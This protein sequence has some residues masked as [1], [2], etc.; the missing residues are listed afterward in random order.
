MKKKRL[1]TGGLLA[2]RILALRLA[3]AGAMLIS[4]AMPAYAQSPQGPA[5]GPTPAPGDLL[6]AWMG[7][8]GSR[9]PTADY[10]GGFAGFVLALNQRNLLGDGWLLRG[11]IYGGVY[12]PS[13]RM[14]GAAMLFGY[15]AAVGP[16]FLSA[17]AGVAYEGHENTPVGAVLTG[18]QGGVK[19]AI[20]YLVPLTGIFE[21]FSIATYTTV[22]D[23]YFAFVRPSFRINPSF[24]FGPEAMAFGNIAYKD[25][26]LGGFIG[27]KMDQ[28]IQRAEIIISGGYLHPTTAG[29]RDGYY[30]NLSL[31]IAR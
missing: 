25:V 6:W 23:T 15:R 14:H 24:R 9:T 30:I 28:L 31:G 1:G 18:T 19:V 12:D 5:V 16:G 3:L 2:M 8:A 7:Y 21:L 27:V 4:A 26:R 22:F 17:Y 10:D 29:N 20:E 13:V 11:E